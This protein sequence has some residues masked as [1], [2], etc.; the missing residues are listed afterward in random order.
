MIPEHRAALRVNFGAVAEVLALGT[1]RQLIALTRDL[2]LGGCFVR[3]QDI[4]PQ[5]TEV[6]VRITSSGETFSAIGRVTGNINAQG[7]GIQFVEIDSENQAV[8]ENW[9][10]L[11]K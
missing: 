9:L 6:Q 1:S 2:S 7:M 5:G 11:R 4:F 3:T 10:D 8:I